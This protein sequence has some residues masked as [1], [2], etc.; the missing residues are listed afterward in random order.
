MNKRDKSFLV[1][2][3]SDG[4]GLE[5]GQSHMS[6]IGNVSYNFGYSEDGIGLG[7]GQSPKTKAKKIGHG[8]KAGLCKNLYTVISK[9]KAVNPIKSKPKF[10]WILDNGHGKFTTETFLKKG[11]KNPGNCSPLLTDK[12]TLSK[13]SKPLLT[14]IDTSLLSEDSKSLLIPVKNDD[15]SIAGYRLLEYKVARDIVKRIIS[16]M[17]GSSYKLLVPEEFNIGIDER[18]RRANALANANTDTIFIF[19]S[20]HTNAIGNGDTWENSSGIETLYPSEKDFCAGLKGNAKTKCEQANKLVEKELVAKSEYLAGCFQQK[21]ALATGWINR[22][23]KPSS[24]VGVLKRTKMTAILT[25]NGFHTN[26]EDCKKLL[27]SYPDW[28][29]RIAQAHVDAMIEIESESK[30]EEFEKTGKIENE[31]K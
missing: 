2:R 16:K 21:L 5:H 29:D 30:W 20:V 13:D 8:V 17:P 6:R 14:D 26:K 27:S 9:K 25:E 19:I 28:R 22:N 24:H 15:G 10:L 12:S 23:I 4:L 11:S 7:Y 3:N 18:V 1:L 31:S